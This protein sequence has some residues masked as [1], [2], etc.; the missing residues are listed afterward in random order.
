[1][2]KTIYVQLPIEIYDWMNNRNGGFV[3]AERQ[4]EVA[5]AMNLRAYVMQ[6]PPESI[7]PAI[8]QINAFCQPIVTSEPP[9]PP[10]EPSEE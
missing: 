10:E 6:D 8:G 5:I 9:A 1:M 3:T 4:I 7:Q 2:M